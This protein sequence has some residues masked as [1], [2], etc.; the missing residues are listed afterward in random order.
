MPC[1]EEAALL[2]H[3][4]A[5]FRRAVSVAGDSLRGQHGRT[6]ER[7]AQMKLRLVETVIVAAMSSLVTW[8]L[9]KPDRA[10]AASRHLVDAA[11]QGVARIASPL[12]PWLWVIAVMS[13]TGGALLQVV[14]M[15]PR[16]N[17]GSWDLGLVLPSVPTLLVGV[18]AGAGL[19][20]FA[21]GLAAAGSWW[22]LPILAVVLHR[23]IRWSQGLKRRWIFQAQ[24]L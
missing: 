6:G 21:G 7:T 18:G 14:A 20:A 16:C 8:A 5:C 17:A 2:R 24:A 9:T 23:G 22:A 3:C 11:T 13:I 12:A 4:A 15:L 1:L 10:S 19:V